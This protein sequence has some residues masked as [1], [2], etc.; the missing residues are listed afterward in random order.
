MPLLVLASENSH[1]SLGCR[2]SIKISYLIETLCHG[3]NDIIFVVDCTD[4]ERIN[5][6]KEDIDNLLIQDKQ[7]LIFANK[8]DMNN[9]IN[10]TEIEN[11]LNLNSIKDRKLYILMQCYYI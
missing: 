7:I 9:A 3:S 5:K 4:R 10:T 8:Q 2:L 11:S 6:V 1:S